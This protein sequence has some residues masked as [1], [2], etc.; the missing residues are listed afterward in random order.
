LKIYRNEKLIKR[1]ARIG[2]IA[3]LGGLGIL[4]LGMVINIYRQDLIEVALGSLLL[5]FLLSQVGIFF[6]NRWGRRPLPDERIDAALKGFDDRWSIYHYCSP[7]N[8]L[9]V[10]PGGI[11]VLLPYYQQG[12]ITYNKGRWSASGGGLIR[13][14]M[15]FFFQEGL[16]R[17]ELEAVDEVKVM[18]RFVDSSVTEIQKAEIQALLVFTHENVEID[19]PEDAPADAVK[20]K[21][22]KEFIRKQAKRTSLAITKVET[23]TQAI[24][25]K[26]A[27]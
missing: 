3:S 5:G 22:L 21:D 8:H 15:R 16:G 18:K 23:I 24:E 27:L 9:L 26:Y 4:I 2:Q 7:V 1:N 13:W 10:G 17:P 12:K 6:G 19:A 20:I 11:W 25:Q 14:Y